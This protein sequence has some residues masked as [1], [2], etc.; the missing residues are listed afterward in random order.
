MGKSWCCETCN[1]S[2]ACDGILWMT[3]GLCIYHG[4]AAAAAAWAAMD[5]KLLLWWDW[6]FHD[7]FCIIWLGNACD[8]V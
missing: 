1:D 3:E 7:W 5:E 6:R 4:C 8:D 2:T